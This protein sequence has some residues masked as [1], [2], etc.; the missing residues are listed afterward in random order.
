MD[1]AFEGLR[2]SYR[3]RS[4]EKLMTYN[5]AY[6]KDWYEA[7][8]ERLRTIRKAWK[9][10]NKE[11]VSA[12]NR[13]LYAANKERK[14]AASRAWYAANKEHANTV[15]RARDLVK[16]PDRYRKAYDPNC[17][18]FPA[19]YD[20]VVGEWV[21]CKQT[22]IPASDTSPE[23]HLAAALIVIDERLAEEEMAA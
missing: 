23:A 17:R 4:K 13:A 8:K 14:N 21:R 7:N 2:G 1:P 5:P 6:A 16:R 12:S 19:T 18:P 22:T 11:R 9:E 10:A 15:Q 20:P 3:R